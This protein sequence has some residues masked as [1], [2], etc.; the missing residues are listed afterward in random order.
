MAFK[1]GRDSSCLVFVLVVDPEEKSDILIYIMVLLH[2]DTH[3][4]HTHTHKLICLHGL[5]YFDFATFIRE[6]RLSAR[7]GLL[8]HLKSYS[9]LLK[10]PEENQDGT[11]RGYRW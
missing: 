4:T 1:T 7:R 11:S 10:I 6:H 2:P 3:T 8:H 5:L 9:L